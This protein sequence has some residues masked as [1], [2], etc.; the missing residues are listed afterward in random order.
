MPEPSLY[1]PIGSPFVELLTVDSTNNYALRALHEGLAPHGA[2]FFAHEQVAG[3]GQR[4]K[5][6][7]AERGNNLILSVVIR[8]ELLALHQQFHLSVCVAVSVWQLFAEKAGEETRIKWP[9]D[10]Y[11]QDRK[12]GGILIESVIGGQNDRTPNNWRWAVA[13]MGIN[14]NQVSFPEMQGRPVSLRQITGKQFDPLLLAQELCLILETNWQKLR[15]GQSE[16]L[17]QTYLA[18]LYKVNQTVRLKKG[19][20]SFDALIKGVSP[21]G[22][23]LVTHALDES[24]QAGEV[25]WIFPDSNTP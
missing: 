9:N 17:F 1:N 21:D 18:N 2:A 24:F 19:S 14:I 11:W 16:E 15:T 3:K 25:E 10:L 5:T 6:W 23:L 13:G 12:A 22:R 7:Q 20:R 4:G 8:P